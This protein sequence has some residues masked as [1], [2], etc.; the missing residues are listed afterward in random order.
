MKEEAP[1]V[2]GSRSKHDEFTKYR[3][4]NNLK[5]NTKLPN[6]VQNVDFSIALV[7]KSFYPSLAHIFNARKSAK[8]NAT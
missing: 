1:V 3:K 5:S 6:I 4:S 8:E 7:I 2:S